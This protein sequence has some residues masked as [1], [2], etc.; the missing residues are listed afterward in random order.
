MKR[1]WLVM[2]LLPAALVVLAGCGG[3]GETAAEPVELTV[4]ATDIAYD[5]P[6]LEAKAGQP[7]RVV[8]DNEGALLHDFSI[9][10]IPLSGE[11]HAEEAHGD[12]MASH[13]AQMS[14]AGETLAVH[15]AAAA[16]SHGEV[17]F[18]PT[19]PGEYEYYCTVPGHKEAGMVGKITITN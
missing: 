2:A 12:D 6:H 13:E 19:T 16:G 15:V 8:L 1:L 4:T 9:H 3:G 17:E 18:T 11:A 7:V 5:T 10:E 14:V